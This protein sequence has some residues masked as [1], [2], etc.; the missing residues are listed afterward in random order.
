MALHGLLANTMT[1]AD[2]E[3]AG[4]LYTYIC[5]M[6]GDDAATAGAA[7]AAAAVEMAAAVMGQQMKSTAAPYGIICSLHSS[8]SR[9]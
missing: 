9:Q 6:I 2:Q 4:L 5:I 8:R 3:P 7:A 1:A